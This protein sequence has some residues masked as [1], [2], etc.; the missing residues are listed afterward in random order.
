MKSKVNSCSIQKD[1][2]IYVSRQHYIN[3]DIL[4]N[5]KDDTP[6]SEMGRKSTSSTAAASFS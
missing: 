6:P 2:N 1:D 3:F 5:E 4:Y